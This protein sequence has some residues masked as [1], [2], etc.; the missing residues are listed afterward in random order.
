MVNE[1]TPRTIVIGKLCMISIMELW[2]IAILPDL[3]AD[4]AKLGFAD[5]TRMISPVW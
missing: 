4:V 1:R 3:A 2:T 5:A